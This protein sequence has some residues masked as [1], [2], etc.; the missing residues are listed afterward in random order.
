[1]RRLSK[2]NEVTP[3]VL[4][5]LSNLSSYVTASNYKIDGGWTAW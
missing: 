3:I 5:L 2:V 4:L 1:M